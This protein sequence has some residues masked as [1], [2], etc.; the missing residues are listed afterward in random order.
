MNFV[1]NEFEHSGTATSVPVGSDLYPARIALVRADQRSE[2]LA[3]CMPEAA[4]LLAVIAW[5]AVYRGGPVINDVGWQLWVG[6]RVNDGARLY[7]D[8]LEVNPPLWFWFAAMIQSAARLAHVSGQ[9]MLLAAFGA[10]AASSILLVRQLLPT[11]PRARAMIHAGL[12]LTLFLT[13]SFALGQREQFTFI[14]MVPYVALIA[15]RAENRPVRWGLAVAIGLFAAAG[16]ALKHYFAII[17][18]ALEAWLLWRRRRMTFRPELAVLALAAAGYVAAIMVF[19][20]EYLTVM[21][22]L[23]LLA[24]DGYGAPPLVGQLRQP[25]LFAGVAAALALWMRRRE[26]PVTAG[27]FAIAIAACATAY[28]LQGKGF[29]Y[30]AIPTLGC[31]LIGLLLG[32]GTAK[33][34]LRFDLGLIAGSLAL[35]GAILAPVTAGPARYDGA[36]AAATARHGRW[37]RSEAWAG[38]PAI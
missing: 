20:P 25:A 21:V 33:V 22:P 24:Y 23:N 4:A 2:R 3:F 14:T 6:Q 13:S 26:L 28:L 36:A 16:F 17:P 34:R 31:A 29:D 35:V 5:M 11:E 37:S 12:I 1:R 19:A 18:I 30:H 15:A 32:F 8:I 38:P 10:C 7:V 9:T 27:A